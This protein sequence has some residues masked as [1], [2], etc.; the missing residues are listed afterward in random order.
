MIPISKKK[1]RAVLAFP[2]VCKTPVPVAGR[3]PI[4]YPNIG[5]Q[6]QKGGTKPTP[7][8]TKPSPGGDQQLR[9]RL[10]MLHAQLTS[11]RGVDPERWHTLLDDYV[12]TTAELFMHNASN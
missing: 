12:M 11:M 4:P 7:G 5:M 6:G 3:V 1:G 2:D 9:S 8:A 10:S